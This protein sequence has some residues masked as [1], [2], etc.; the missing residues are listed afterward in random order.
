[1]VEMKL[2]EAVEKYKNILNETAASNIEKTKNVEDAETE[3]EMFW[4]MFIIYL[5]KSQRLLDLLPDPIG[6]IDRKIGTTAPDSQSALYNEMD[7]I[8]GVTDTS[9]NIVDIQFNNRQDLIDNYKAS[10]EYYI[11]ESAFYSTDTNEVIFRFFDMVPRADHRQCYKYSSHDFYYSPL[12]EI[13]E[14]APKLL[15]RIK[16][17]AYKRHSKLIFKTM[18]EGVRGGLQNT[19][20]S[21]I[22]KESDT[23]IFLIFKDPEIQELLLGDYGEFEPADGS[24]YTKSDAIEDSKA[25]ADVD[26]ER[27]DAIKSFDELKYFIDMPYIGWGQFKQCINLESIELPP[28]ITRIKDN[29]FENCIKLKRVAL[30]YTGMLKEI[31]CMAFANTAI[32]ELEIPEG[33]EI[34]RDC[35]FCDC[36]SLKRIKLPTTLT[37]IERNVF[38]GCKTLQTV[39]GLENIDKLLNAYA[40]RNIF[41]D[42]PIA[43][44]YSEYKKDEP[45]VELF[46]GSE[47]DFESWLKDEQESRCTEDDW[48]DSIF[49][50]ESNNYDENELWDVFYEYWRNYLLDT[51]RELNRKFQFQKWTTLSG[52]LYDDLDSAISDLQNDDLEHIYI[53]QY[54][55]GLE[56]D[57]T[58]IYPVFSEHYLEG[59]DKNYTSVESRRVTNRIQGYI[60]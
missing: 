23:N 46:D 22:D 45:Y 11:V 27:N 1:M 41:Y 51:E 7:V 48:N 10:Y 2:S 14:G 34:I 13:E 21:D 9:D 53:A 28:N 38:A 58:F 35:A 37:K 43:K 52:I 24:I 5:K 29:A 25:I 32:E 39:E 26:F 33:V 36:K 31:G 8:I 30:P 44:Q 42:C 20:V 16:E 3:L 54:N 12:S 15:Q 4:N 56:F 17:M 60:L 49:N 6:M 57:G 19:N 50:P 40:K 59:D 47:M 18:N 55:G